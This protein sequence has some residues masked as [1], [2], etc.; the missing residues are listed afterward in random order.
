MKR[1][2]QKKE[3][4]NIELELRPLQVRKIELLRTIKETENDQ[5][6]N[7]NDGLIFF[8][9]WYGLF[10]A[11]ALFY[12]PFIGPMLSLLIA[13]GFVYLYLK[14]GSVKKEKEELEEIVIK[15]DALTRK[16]DKIKERFFS[17]N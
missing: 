15:V 2:S 12:V 1:S 9:F 14:I 6:Y 11:F 17:L 7:K 8:L 4:D 16:K 3:Y 13:I 5:Y 10:L